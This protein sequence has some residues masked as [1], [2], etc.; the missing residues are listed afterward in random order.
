[1]RGGKKIG[2]DGIFLKGKINAK[3]LDVYKSVRKVIL[4]KL[5]NYSQDKKN[6]QLTIRKLFLSRPQRI[7]RASKFK[8]LT[9]NLVILNA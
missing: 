3:G 5:A 7:F 9:Q 6:L 2:F 8:R 1:M 4:W